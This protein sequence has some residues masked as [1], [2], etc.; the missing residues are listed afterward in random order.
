MEGGYLI[1]IPVSRVSEIQWLF[2]KGGNVPRGKGSPCARHQ[3]WK[4][5][6]LVDH[7]SLIS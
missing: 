4:R 7:Q 2:R 6:L 3:R 1:W 5:M